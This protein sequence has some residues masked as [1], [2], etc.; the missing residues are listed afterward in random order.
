[1]PPA[2]EPDLL[3]FSHCIAGICRGAGKASVPMFIMLACWC[4]IRI[5]YITVAMHFI[6]S[7]GVVF[8]AYPL[9]WGLSSIAF[10]FY[11]LY[12]DWIHAF[13]RREQ[14]GEERCE[15]SETA[16]K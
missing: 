10:L 9:T 4:L 8:W 2:Y 7:I 13:E 1:M 16:S 12:S 11:Y 6:H 15:S 14:S 5:L 3:A